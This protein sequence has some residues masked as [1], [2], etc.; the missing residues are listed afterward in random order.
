[1]KVFKDIRFWCVLLFLTVLL[2]IALGLIMI[3]TP[4]YFEAYRVQ[5]GDTLWA[6]AEKSNGFG[7]IDRREI[8]AQMELYSGV[9][10][11]IQ[12]GDIVYIPMYE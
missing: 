6:I 7:T 3:E 5:S 8:I 1:M 2:V 11:D 4:S 10:A 12:P 9:T